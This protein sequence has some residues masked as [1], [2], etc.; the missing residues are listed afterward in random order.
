MVYSQWNSKQLL[1]TGDI[2]RREH[3]ERKVGN[4]VVFKSSYFHLYG[5][6]Y[7]V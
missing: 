3:R 7:G 4:E 2:H 1:T 5:P 6:V